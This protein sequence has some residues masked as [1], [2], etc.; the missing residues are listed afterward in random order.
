VAIEN[1]GKLPLYFEANR[2]QA[3]G[4]VKYLTRLPE[5]T[6]FLNEEDAV[7]QMRR[8]KAQGDAGEAVLRMKLAGAQPARRIEG[9]E[10]Q[11][12]VANYLLGKNPAH[13][14]TDIPLFQKVRYEEVYPGIDLVYYGNR[15]RLEFDFIV[16]AGA[17][18]NAVRLEFSGMKRMKLTPRG[19]LVLENELGDVRYDKPVLYQE[20]KGKRVPVDG[21][22]RLLAGA[23]VG[24][25]VGAYDRNLP[26]VI[27]PML[28]YST[29]L[30]GATELTIGHNVAVSPAGEVFV[31]GHTRAI[32]Y[33][34][35]NAFQSFN[36]GQADVFVTKITGTGLGYS[37]YLGG[38]GSEFAFGL[39]VDGEG[40]AYITGDT[41]SN[42]F[43]VQNAS[44]GTLGG[45]TDI[46]LTKL[47]N[48]G[49]VLLFSTYLGG[50]N[51]ETAAYHTV[52]VNRT[53]G[54]AYVTGTTSSTNFPV[55]AALQPNLGGCSDAIVAKYFNTGVKQFATYLGGLGCDNG[56]G[57]AVDSGQFIYVTGS[58]ASDNFP[59]T[60]EVIQPTRAGGTD[61]FITKLPPDGSFLG[62]STYFGGTGND[63]GY[64]IGVH[65]ATE[66]PYVTGVTTSVDLPTTAGVV[67]PVPPSG[68]NAFVTRLAKNFKSL[69]FST[70]LGG[71]R[72][73]VGYAIAVQGS[74][75][76]AAVTGYTH[77]DDF[78][79]ASPLQQVK[80]GEVKVAYRS[81]NNGGNWTLSDAG[82]G[83]DGVNGFSL[84]PTN[85]NS[86][87]A[88][89]Y[90]GVFKSTDGGAAWSATTGV[91][92][93]HIHSVSQSAG[94]VAYAAIGRPVWKSTDAGSTWAAASTVPAA[95]IVKVV[96]A[97]PS[98]ANKVYAGT[99][100]HGVFYSESGGTSWT[101][102]STGLAAKKINALV[103]SP[104]NSAV[105]YAGTVGGGA[106]KTTNGGAAWT[107][108]NTGIGAKA[109]V[110]S[111]SIH[112]TDPN[113]VYAARG[114]CVMKTTDG[115]A[116]WTQS[117]C[118][119][120]GEV[121]V[122][123][124]EPNIV[125]AGS[126][127]RGVW[128]SQDGGTNWTLVNSG[129]A[130]TNV[131]ALALL[132][133]SAVLAGTEVPPNAFVTRLDANGAGFAPYSTHL[134]NLSFGRGIAFDSNGN[135][136]VA[137]YTMDPQFPTTTTAYRRTFGAQQ[138]FL[139][140][141]RDAAG[142]NCFLNT[143]P[144]SKFFYQI[145]GDQTITVNT[146]SGCAWTVTGGDTWLHILEG[147]S[148]TGVGT[149]SIHADANTGAARTANL[150]VGSATI[151]IQQAAA[152]CSY[153]L[154]PNSIAPPAAGG[155]ANI[156]VTAGA[157]CDWI[158]DRNNYSWI[159]VNT[160]ASGTGNGTVNLTIAA[161]NAVVPRTATL[162]IGTRLLN[163]NQA[164]GSGGQPGLRT[165]DLGVYRNGLWFT[166]WDSSRSWTPVDAA[167]VF[168]F[169]L[170]GDRP[171][172][173]DWNG[174][175]T[176]K[177]GVYRNGHWFVD[178]NGNRG[179][180]AED[181]AHVFAFGLP[182][183]WPVMGDW[184][185]DGIQK[186]G[187]FRNG[188]WFVDWNGNRV[189]DAED[190]AHIFAFGLPGDRPILGDWT[191]DGS[192][193]LGVYRNGQWLVDWN[194]SRGWDAED[195]AHIFVFGLAG[196]LPVVGDWSRTGTQKIGVFRN[197]QWLVDFNGNYTW[198]AT[199]A[200]NIFSF[201]LPGD[202]PV[203]SKWDPSR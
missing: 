190:A 167:H 175:G 117:Q 101:P 124:S 39:D 82:L 104:S 183:D 119:S 99:E 49:N 55:L 85:A 11:A 66:T 36:K 199:D 23:R 156:T 176:Q 174:D 102:R 111:I 162:A 145:G 121:A 203:Q 31:T 181:A 24:F 54:E 185:G 125:Y 41:N 75:G 51:A 130:H 92:T 9:L 134:G 5:L 78:P 25:T 71:S 2:G 89:T 50:S 68:S 46:F 187:V 81:V 21:S 189:W 48:A 163:I 171:V 198:D 3:D 137:G 35:A 122:A 80:G 141:I 88:A 63:D 103:M 29:F 142:T 192:Q 200:A 178:W 74:S 127:V 47:S 98:D 114:G 173:G 108:V 58:T 84:D 157:G 97:H 184:N 72:T 128:R 179:W 169:G 152:G 59:V 83:A 165:D 91:A 118:D 76:G 26:L 106:Y 62:V 164:K 120:I 87:L 20:H 148:G 1:Y 77:S 53:T 45:G 112:P 161:N 79:L 43:P 64:D 94:G 105:L 57:I 201:G 95:S 15:E 38:A 147:S 96:V 194:G 27:D 143:F 168:P 19:E 123:A 86:V 196:D 182:G 146:P 18:P 129:I 13:W 138:A 115:G 69:V 135:A 126:G 159:T 12:G 67:Q 30:G 14:R 90:R 177:L 155:T 150:T 149:I 151:P 131:R 42:N 32:D 136:N 153:S 160:G 93:A 195:A 4:K 22:Y 202:L 144:A 113:T 139:T 133:S 6:V 73:D 188:Q 8:Q 70:Y 37:T 197:G 17:D 107:A 186:P 180:D 116:N 7:I 172:L 110:D 60:P 100:S 158:T 61:L 44:Q 10:K 56:R 166:D 191:L 52:Q 140:R 65:S 33:P 109:T 132:T 40:N 28:L 154:K 34:V 170:P 16:S 193:K